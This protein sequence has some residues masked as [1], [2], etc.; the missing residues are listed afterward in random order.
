[1]EDKVSLVSVGEHTNPI[2]HALVQQQGIVLWQELLQPNADAVPEN[3]NDFS[4]HVPTDPSEEA[5]TS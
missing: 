1:M 3:Q 5:S 4:A 2:L